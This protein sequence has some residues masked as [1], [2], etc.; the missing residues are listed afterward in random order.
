MVWQVSPV[1][2]LLKKVILA[3]PKLH[4][5]WLLLQTG[6]STR[7]CPNILFIGKHAVMFSVFQEIW[8]GYS[9]T[10]A[11]S[12][13]SCRYFRYGSDPTQVWGV[14]HFTYLAYHMHKSGRRISI[15]LVIALIKWTLDVSCCRW[16][17]VK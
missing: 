14:F 7:K 9:D 3:E 16:F 17:Q 2:G 1:L 11:D 5:V 8:Y 13:V 15:W 4:T 12:M 6:V 10:E